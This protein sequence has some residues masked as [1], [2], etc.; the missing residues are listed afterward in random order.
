MTWHLFAIPGKVMFSILKSI[1][2]LGSYVVVREHRSWH[3]HVWIIIFLYWALYV[4]CLYPYQFGAVHISRSLRRPPNSLDVVFV[5]I[6]ACVAKLPKPDLEPWHPPAASESRLA[7]Y[8][9]HSPPRRNDN[10]EVTPPSS[11]RPLQLLPCGCLRLLLF[12]ARS[13]NKVSKWTS[14]RWFKFDKQSRSHG[15]MGTLVWRGTS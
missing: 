13:K 10:F 8:Q 7:K 2:E 15:H 12:S 1:P 11:V 5:H 9:P 6:S 14:A 4:H 3:L